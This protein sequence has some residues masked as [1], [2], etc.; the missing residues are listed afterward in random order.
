MNTDDVKAPTKFLRCLITDYLKIETW[1]DCILTAFSQENLVQ[2]TPY[3]LW[4]VEL[5]LSK[6][7]SLTLKKMHSIIW[8]LLAVSWNSSEAY[9][10]GV[11]WL[12][13][14]FLFCYWQESIYFKSI[15]HCLGELS[16]SLSTLP[17]S[18][19]EIQHTAESAPYF[20][21]CVLFSW[22]PV[23]RF[24]FPSSAGNLA[25]PRGWDRPAGQFRVSYEPLHR[26]A[27]GRA[28]AA[29]GLQH[30]AQS[31]LHA[32]EDPWS[33]KVRE[34]AFKPLLCKAFSVFCSLCDCFI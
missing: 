2:D 5:W 6:V 26:A 12:L 27:A 18:L 8:A 15:S 33:G 4:L 10:E 29:Q 34:I 9:L 19:C 22:I 32:A 16:S 21:S 13:W 11:L 31:L 25:H 17:L 14:A 20:P 30:P 28:R 23:W 1:C 7:H 24:P 3:F